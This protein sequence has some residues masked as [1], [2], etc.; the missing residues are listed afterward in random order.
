M[1]YFYSIDFA[2]FTT[3]SNLTTGIPTTANLTTQ[4]SLL[5]N[6]TT[7]KMLFSLHFFVDLHTCM[8]EVVTMIAL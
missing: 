6:L 2:C 7:R 5:S 1:Y 4:F 3:T 8:S